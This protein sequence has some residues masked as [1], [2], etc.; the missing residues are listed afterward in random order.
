M[1]QMSCAYEQLFYDIANPHTLLE[2]DISDQAFEQIRR[3]DQSK[4]PDHMKVCQITEQIRYGDGYA[5]HEYTVE[6]E[7][8]DGLSA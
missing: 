7:G 1:I 2:Q 3:M 4:D 8:D 5:Q 6:Q